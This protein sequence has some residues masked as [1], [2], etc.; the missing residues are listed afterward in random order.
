MNTCIH[1]IYLSLTLKTN[2]TFHSSCGA[3]FFTE[4]GMSSSYDINIVY[5]GNVQ[6]P[7]QN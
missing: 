4:F 1:N 2:D 6:I 5:T 7:Y 3:E